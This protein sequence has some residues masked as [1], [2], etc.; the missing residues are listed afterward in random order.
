MNLVH[1]IGVIRIKYQCNNNVQHKLEYKIVVILSRLYQANIAV[2]LV[3][4]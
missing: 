2:L 3:C 1:T 4:L